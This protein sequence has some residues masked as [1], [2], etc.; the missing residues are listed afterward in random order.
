MF[1]T[2]LAFLE[3]DLAMYTTDG[4]VVQPDVAYWI[5]SE[6]DLLVVDGVGGHDLVWLE[7]LH[8]TESAK[9]ANLA[10]VHDEGVVF[11]M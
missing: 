1:S 3:D 5:S 2:Y 6:S 9:A 8:Q 11:V 4:L 7:S 10:G